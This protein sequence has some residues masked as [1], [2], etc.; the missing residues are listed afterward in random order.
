MDLKV[1][2][3]WEISNFSKDPTGVLMA[4]R[5]DFLFLC[6]NLKKL[7]KTVLQLKT[8]IE[9][10]ADL[11]TAV[12]SKVKVD[13]QYDGPTISDIPVSKRVSNTSSGSD[14]SGL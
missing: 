1:N 2:P 11:L 10:H 7:E 8:D 12:L 13:E 3:R 4:V 14:A 9:K 5:D 6:K